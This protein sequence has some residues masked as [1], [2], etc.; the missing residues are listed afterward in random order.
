MIAMAKGSGRIRAIDHTAAPNTA[1][2]ASSAPLMTLNATTPAPARK[3]TSLLAARLGAG[4]VGDGM[5]ATGTVSTTGKVTTG[6]A[7]GGLGAAES[8]TPVDEVFT[9]R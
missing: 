2:F 5:A 7:C 1:S 6:F 4:G 3:P 8:H 9:P